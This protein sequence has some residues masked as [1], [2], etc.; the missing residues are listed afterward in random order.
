[1]RQT[2]RGAAGASQGGRGPGRGPGRASG[3]LNRV[4]A[5]LPAARARAPAPPSA[6][7]T[8]FSIA[9]HDARAV[10]A[11]FE[12]AT[13]AGPR[14]GAGAAG[15]APARGG[16][17]AQVGERLERAFPGGEAARVA[18]SWRMAQAGE[19]LRV[20][21]G[22]QVGRQEVR[23]R[24]C[25]AS[26]PGPA[27]PAP[28]ARLLPFPGAPTSPPRPG[29]TEFGRRATPPPRARPRR[30]CS[31]SRPSRGGRWRTCPGWGS[32]RSTPRRSGTSSP[33]RRAPP[34]CRRGT[35]CGPPPRGARRWPTGRSGRREASR[36]AARPTRERPT[37]EAGA[38]SRACA[39]P[40][41]CCRTAGGGTRPTAPCS[42]GRWPPSRRPA[43]PAWRSSS[44]GSPAAR[45]SSPT[46]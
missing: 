9:G 26:L 3:A 25:G 20:D 27:P 39:R 8:D 42:P 32:W 44:P 16:F 30:R 21:H 13:A 11:F 31:G 45:A 34:R 17:E 10:D 22:P 33:P 5:G 6:A 35:T 19:S 1:M 36:R 24:S 46:R 23:H 38:D 14:D 43:C 28:R 12:N 40:G 15:G 18:A 41:S 4:H 29:L 37:G 2:S 7:K